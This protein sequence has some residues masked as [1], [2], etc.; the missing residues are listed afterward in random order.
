MRSSVHVGNVIRSNNVLTYTV[1]KLSTS[2]EFLFWLSFLTYL[3]I[4][5]E[6]DSLLRLIKGFARPWLLIITTDSN[7]AENSVGVM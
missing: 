3:A 7:V 2:S 1:Y 6:L 5:M 4:I